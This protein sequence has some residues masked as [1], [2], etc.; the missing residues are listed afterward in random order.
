MYAVVRFSD[1]EK[2]VIPRMW[3]LTPTIRLNKKLL[4]FYHEDLNRKVPEN[5]ELLEIWKNGRSKSGYLHTIYVFGLKGMSVKYFLADHSEF[6]R[7]AN[8]AS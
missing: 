6:R 2:A 8:F 3:I 1:G 7:T 5:T 4:A